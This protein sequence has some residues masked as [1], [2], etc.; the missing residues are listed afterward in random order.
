MLSPKKVSLTVVTLG[1]GLVLGGGC[2]APSPDESLGTRVDEH[3]I[4]SPWQGDDAEKAKEAGE[5]AA[6]ET[7]ETGEEAAKKA[8]ETKEEAAEEAKE[9]GEEAK[10]K[11]E[12]EAEERGEEAEEAK[13][14]AAEEAKECGEEAAEEAEEA[15][16]K[17]AEE[18]EEKV[19][20]ELRV[21]DPRDP[22]FG[23]RH[24]H[25]RDHRWGR[26]RDRL[27]RARVCNVR[28]DFHCER[29]HRGWRWAWVSAPTADRHGRPG[30]HDRRD[31]A[32]CCVR[33]RDHRR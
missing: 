5:E 3:V 26:D 9:R 24:P 14:K 2:V 20:Q 1:A 7:K 23:R 27:H 21:D 12:E 28:D 4:E 15:K 13:E 25:D 18:A 33:V 11:A 22:R 17:A 16:E 30:H 6:K 29:G 19:D 10:E 31:G 8:E 32:R